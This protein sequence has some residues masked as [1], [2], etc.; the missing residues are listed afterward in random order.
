VTV[1]SLTA[2]IILNVSVGLNTQTDKLYGFSLIKSVWAQ[3]QEEGPACDD[4][5]GCLD[6][7]ECRMKDW[8]Q[9]ILICEGANN[10]YCGY[11]NS[12]QNPG[13]N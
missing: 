8:L 6:D 3:S 5:S 13:E 9:D 4:I 1:L 10:V 2:L 11:D 12:E 7:G